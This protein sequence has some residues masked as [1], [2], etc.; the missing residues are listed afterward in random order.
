MVVAEA[1]MAV[2]SASAGPVT[3][4]VRQLLSTG[5]PKRV[6]CRMTSWLESTQVLGAPSALA[7][8]YTLAIVER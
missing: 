8:S 1:E 2:S 4:Q 5:S 3:G 7:G 6:V